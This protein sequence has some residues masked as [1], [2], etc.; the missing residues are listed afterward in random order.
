[1][2]GRLAKIGQDGTVVVGG[3][4]TVV[5]IRRP[6]GWLVYRMALDEDAANAALLSDE[7]VRVITERLRDPI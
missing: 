2:E 1:V 4:C 5:W 6:V 7:D 3:R